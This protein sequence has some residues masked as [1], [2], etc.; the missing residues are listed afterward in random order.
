MGLNYDSSYNNVITNMSITNEVSGK[1]FELAEGQGAALISLEPINELMIS[2][3][4]G[5]AG[6]AFRELAS[7]I[8]SELLSTIRF[9]Y[10]AGDISGQQVDDFNTTD[11]ESTDALNVTATPAGSSSDENG[12]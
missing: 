7:T 2:S 11:E 9:D 6:E 1:Y 3:W 10:S 12:G 4:H 8:E 5:E